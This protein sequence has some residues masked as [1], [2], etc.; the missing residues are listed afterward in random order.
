[1]IFSAQL[2]SDLVSTNVRQ[3]LTALLHQ[4]APKKMQFFLFILLLHIS[5]DLLSDFHDWLCSFHVWMG[6]QRRKERK[7][8]LSIA[9]QQ[10]EAEES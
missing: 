3:I 4:S 1:M 2:N 7:D 10:L 8:S 6:Q 5:R 9:K